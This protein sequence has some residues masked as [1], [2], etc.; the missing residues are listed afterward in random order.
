M[1]HVVFL[2]PFMGLNMYR[3]IRPIADFPGVKLSLVTQQP[4]EFIPSQL[5]EK[6]AGHYKVGNAL[7]PGQ[8]AIAVRHLANSVGP[9]YRFFG[10]M[11][12]LQIPLAKVRDYLKIEGMDTR[13]AINFRE[14][15]VMKDVLRS[16][17]LPC[18]KHCLASSLEDAQAF[19]KQIGYPLVIKPPAGVG[20]RNTFE[21]HDDESLKHYV[22]GFAPSKESPILLEEFIQGEEYSFETFSIQGKPVWTSYTRYYPRPLEVMKNPWI[23]WCV[24]MP[25]QRVNPEN[26]DIEKA[27]YKALEVLG[28]KTGLSHME[29]FR[30]KDGSIAISEVAARPPGAMIMPLLWHAHDFDFYEAW[31]KLMV[32]DYFDAPER[33]YSSGC[34]FLRGMG[35]GR[36]KAVHG[37]DK[38]KETL[39][40]LVVE[41]TIPQKGQPQSPSYEGDGKI[42]VRHPD[43][44]IVK[45]ALSLI[46][47]NVRVEYDVRL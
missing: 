31:G 30:R 33:K 47:S 26:Q 22:L 6:L 10:A 29:W 23:Q 42:V 34:A 40:D 19:A 9:V 4:S 43:V 20:T 17:G 1:K 44:E 38:I 45:K 32:F 11:E 25:A 27:N 35:K 18:A 28:M 8:L 7:D 13:T 37:L 5:K 16:N 14:K 46:I 21:I 24:L 12:E 41:T 36:V 3:F 39:G 2:T 15:H